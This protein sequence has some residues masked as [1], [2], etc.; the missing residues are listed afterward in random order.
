M[1]M[2]APQGNDA[3]SMAEAAAAGVPAAVVV[4]KVATRVAA[5][6]AALKRGGGGSSCRSEKRP[7][8]TTINKKH[9]RVRQKWQTWLRREQ[10]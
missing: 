9:Q 2:V 3:T 5:A 8:Q 4:E 6:A 7:G 1:T 10:S